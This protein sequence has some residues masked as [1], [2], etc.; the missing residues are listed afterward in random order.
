MTDAPSLLFDPATMHDPT[1][2]CFMYTLGDW[3]VRWPP[4][5]DL[6]PRWLLVGLFHL[7]LYA[8]EHG[9]SVLVFHRS[10]WI[11]TYALRTA[12]GDCVSVGS[13]VEL[14]AWLAAR[15]IQ[16]PRFDRVDRLADLAFRRSLAALGNMVAA[17]HTC[18]V[19]RDRLAR[20]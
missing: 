16:G 9:V 8:P 5:L 4:R 20:C 18:P 12:D 10:R 14:A 3:E 11:S 15:G 7:H 13:R 19:H 6:G 2:R 17:T 1:P